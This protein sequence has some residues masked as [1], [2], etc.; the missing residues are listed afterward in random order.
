MVTYLSRAIEHLS[1][2]MGT[3]DHKSPIINNFAN[4]IVR[5][6]GAYSLACITIRSV[7]VPMPGD[8]GDLIHSFECVRNVY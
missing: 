1:V 7:S 6:G 2:V 4:S 3:R 8:S 5:V